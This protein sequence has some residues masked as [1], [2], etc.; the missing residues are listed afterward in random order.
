MEVKSKGKTRL[1]DVEGARPSQGFSA[2]AMNDTSVY[3][4]TECAALPNGKAVCLEYPDPE[5]WV[6]ITGLSI[7]E[8]L[9]IG[10]VA[11]ALPI[12]VNDN[13][14]AAG[15]NYA[16]IVQNGIKYCCWIESYYWVNAEVSVWTFVVD[17]WHTAADILYVQHMFIEQ[18]TVADDASESPYILASNNIPVNLEWAMATISADEWD[19][20]PLQ[21]VIMQDPAVLTQST[22]ITEDQISAPNG[23]AIAGKLYHADLDSKLPVKTYLENLRMMQMPPGKQAYSVITS[24]KIVPKMIVDGSGETSP[25]LYPT[26]VP[27]VPT[28]GFLR[29]GR[30]P[31][32]SVVLSVAGNGSVKW[33]VTDFGDFSGTQQIFAWT[34]AQPPS[35]SFVPYAENGGVT[36]SNM[37]KAFTASNWPDMPYNATSSTAFSHAIDTARQ[38][39]GMAGSNLSTAANNGGYDMGRIVTA[40][41]TNMAAAAGVGS[42]VPAVGTLAGGGIGL[43]AGAGA[44]FISQSLHGFMHPGAPLPE[45]ASNT[46]MVDYV[47]TPILNFAD[48]VFGKRDAITIANVSQAG[49]LNA[50]DLILVQ[51][52]VPIESYV[53]PLCDMWLWLGYNCN[54]YDRNFSVENH[55]KKSLGGYFFIKG[56]PITSRRASY[57]FKNFAAQLSA[58]VHC[59]QTYDDLRKASVPVARLNNDGGFDVVGSEDD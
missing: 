1:P 17:I 18:C 26:T 4:Y 54:Y 24:N 16:A 57:M 33:D 32:G 59:W 12:G 50:N 5:P 29:L 48:A 58:G 11:I 6:E 39:A 3:I 51:H 30:P 19:R 7:A 23:I 52:V 8:N 40:G 37:A 10:S 9:N 25:K 34:I 36:Y 28:R 44:E 43:L 42:M 27:R 45:K 13:P 21:L 49:A 46:A 38:I 47:I 14:E 15:V 56:I 31:F 35:I 53:K 41:A 2:R 20:T 22:P 55:Q